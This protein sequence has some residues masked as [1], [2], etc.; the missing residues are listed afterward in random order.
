MIIL[1]L[2][3]FQ[4]SYSRDHI[5]VG[6]III[7]SLVKYP[8]VMRIFEKVSGGVYSCMYLSMQ[9]HGLCLC[10]GCGCVCICEIYVGIF[11]LLQK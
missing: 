2:N 11:L 8:Q 3:E 5:R 7:I 6:R 10:L 1:L 9:V 4:L